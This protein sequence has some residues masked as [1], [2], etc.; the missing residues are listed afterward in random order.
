[1]K[2]KRWSRLQKATKA[3]WMQE[4]QKENATELIRQAEA[5]GWCFHGEEACIRRKDPGRR[6]GLLCSNE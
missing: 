4:K 2:K 1:M 5:A 6:Q 3:F